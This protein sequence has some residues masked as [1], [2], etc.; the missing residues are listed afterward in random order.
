MLALIDP[1]TALYDSWRA[2]HQEWGPGLHEDGFGLTSSDD[3]GS[4]SGF[5]AWVARLTSES[6]PTGQGHV[7]T[8]LPTY[9]WIVDGEEVLGG[10][11]L[12]THPRDVVLRMGHVG[13]GI[14]PSARRRGGATWA[15]GRMLTEAATQGLDRVLLVCEVGNTASAATIEALGGVLDDGPHAD[16]LDVRRY[17][18]ALRGTVR[19]RD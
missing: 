7:G 9:R 2:A 14:R 13:F 17:W 11:A 18:I 8:T 10:I 19:T 3:V 4:F 1:T 6:T 15:L 5:C 12:R 16:D